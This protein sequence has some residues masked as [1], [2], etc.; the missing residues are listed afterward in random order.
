MVKVALLISVSAAMHLEKIR[1][2]SCIECEHVMPAENFG[3]HLQCWRNGGRKECKKD[4]IF[5][6]IK[7]DLHNLQPSID[8]VSGDRSNYCYYQFTKTFN[9]YGQCQTAVDFKQRQFQPREEI[10]GVIARTYFYMQ[11][12]YNI[13]LSDAQSKLMTAW[14]NAYLPNECERNKQIERI[15]SNDNRFITEK[16]N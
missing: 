2:A 10:R 5:N 7:G 12:K 3:R 8:E 4:V 14:D 6:T 16:C 11:D 1:R 15:Q 9:Q 13:N